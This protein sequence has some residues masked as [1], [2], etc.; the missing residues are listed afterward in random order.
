[1]WASEA[2]EPMITCGCRPPYAEIQ[3]DAPAREHLCHWGHSQAPWWPPCWAGSR[4]PTH[5]EAGCE[6]A[7]GYP[8]GCLCQWLGSWARMYCCARHVGVATTEKIYIPA[9]WNQ[10]WE[11]QKARFG[12]G[13]NIAQASK[14]EP[15]REGQSRLLFNRTQ[16]FTYD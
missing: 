14:D 8:H 16:S 9:L 3:V 15:R 11:L 1:M 2:Q 5:Q 6:V 7:A 13:S 10:V 4:E 12:R